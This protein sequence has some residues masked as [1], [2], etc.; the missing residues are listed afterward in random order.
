[1]LQCWSELPGDRPTFPSLVC[2]VGDLLEDQVRQVSEGSHYFTL[3]YNVEEA[4]HSTAAVSLAR[5][6]LTLLVG[7][8]VLYS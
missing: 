8:T 3:T 2:G 5:M 7:S 1:M 4:I 6:L